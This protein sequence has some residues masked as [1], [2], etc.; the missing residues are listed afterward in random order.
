[1]I[2]FYRKNKRILLIITTALLLIVILF[3]INSLKNKQSVENQQGRLV[4]AQNKSAQPNYVEH[5]VLVKFKIN[6]IDLNNPADDY[7]LTSFYNANN[8]DEVTKLKPQ[9]VVLI[10]SDK[11]TTAELIN[12]LK[13]NPIVEYAEPNYL[14]QAQTSPN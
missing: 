14:S 10:K 9:N 4:N 13:N 1:M 7:K 3:V 8:V 2:S 6:E 12:K 11:K 5:E